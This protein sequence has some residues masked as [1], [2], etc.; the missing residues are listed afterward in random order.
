MTL[1]FW[2][3]LRKSDEEIANSGEHNSKS[4]QFPELKIGQG[5]SCHTKVSKTAVGVSCFSVD[6]V[7]MPVPL[8]ILVPGNTQENT[9]PW[10]DVPSRLSTKQ[11]GHS[12]PV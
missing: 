2:R 10:D 6:T 9:L 7:C 8:Y 12:K 4:S 11:G 3:T 1:V 5:G